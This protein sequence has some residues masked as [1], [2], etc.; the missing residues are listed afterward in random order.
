[1]TQTPHRAPRVPPCWSSAG[2]AF[3]RAKSQVDH[4]RTTKHLIRPAR[5]TQKYHVSRPKTP[6]TPKQ[7]ALPTIIKRNL[8][9]LS[10]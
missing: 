10:P 1:M 4:I 7:T 6:S 8:A 9:A 2:S 5:G 3:A